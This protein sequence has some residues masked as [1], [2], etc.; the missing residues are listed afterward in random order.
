M[1]DNEHFSR[2]ARR[3]EMIGLAASAGGLA[4]ITILLGALP[5]DFPL[6][7]IIVQH[8]ARDKISLMAQ[9]LQK[10][11]TLHV[12]QAEDG[13]H[14]DGGTVYIAPPDWHVLI[15]PGANLCLSHAEAVHFS[16]PSA[17]VLFESMAK[18][19]AERGIAIVLSGSG[20]DGMLGAKGVKE[21]GGVVIAQDSST[22]EFFG[23]PGAVIQ[24]GSADFILPLDEI[25]LMLVTLTK[26]GKD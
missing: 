18:S 14:A 19:Y 26:I 6:P 22:S 8:L 3:F 10:H 25:A 9:I 16:R 1:Q 24:S 15:E 2:A 17:D 11:T 20:I 13:E 12:K 4:A 5:A 21:S 7:I 23:M